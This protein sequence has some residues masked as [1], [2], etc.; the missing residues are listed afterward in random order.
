MVVPRSLFVLLFGAPLALAAIAPRQDAAPTST[1]DPE[2]AVEKFQAIAMSIAPEITPPPKLE[3]Y[4]TTAEEIVNAVKTLA[5]SD[6]GLG[7]TDEVE[8]WCSLE[9]LGPLA[10]IRPTDPAMLKVMTSWEA[11]RSSARDKWSSSVHSLATRCGTING[12][13]GGY[14]MSMVASNYDEC[15]SARSVWKELTTINQG[16]AAAVATKTA[17]DAA[18]QGQTKTGDITTNTSTSTAGAWRGR[19]TAGAM[20]VVAGVI[21]TIS[22]AQQSSS[23]DALYSLCTSQL[24]AY[25][26]LRPSPA[27]DVQSFFANA[28]ELQ[29]PRNNYWDPAEIDLQ[30]RY[31]WEGR[32]SMGATAAPSLAS[33]F[34]AFT[35]SWN[36]W[37]GSVKEEALEWA[38]RCN[39][40][41]GTPSGEEGE[42]D[43]GDKE[44]KRWGAHFYA[45]IIT[46][47]A[48]CRTAVSD[49][50]GVAEGRTRTTVGMATVT[51]VTTMS[52]TRTTTMTSTSSGEVEEVVSTM[53]ST[54]GIAQMTG[55]GGVAMGVVAVGGA[56][57]GGLL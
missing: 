25:Q 2:C 52:T 41:A 53:T 10:K 16:A 13:A 49:W 19:E 35:S 3:E 5:P 44:N 20:V 42:V 11:Q 29:D 26:R 24:N 50:L 8:V 31:I 38:T 54:G 17:E 9:Y 4:L 39:E 43:G 55:L 21:D 1:D 22:P 37:V 6:L 57:V 27:R 23:E 30:C 47:E 36:S 28:P 34:S 40:F 48:G 45:L 46:D 56:V 18:V 7:G 32:N 33:Q 15:T 51:G 12:H 14:L